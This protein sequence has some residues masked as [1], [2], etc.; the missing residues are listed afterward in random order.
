MKKEVQ[1][2]GIASLSKGYHMHI[3]SSEMKAAR[4]AFFLQTHTSFGLENGLLTAPVW[5]DGLGAWGSWVRVPPEDSEIETPKLI[6]S[7]N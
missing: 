4:N 5:Y 1:M 2:T 7:P 6:A 3:T